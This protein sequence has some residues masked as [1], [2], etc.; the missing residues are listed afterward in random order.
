M[1][2]VRNSEVTIEVWSVF[3]DFCFLVKRLISN[4]DLFFF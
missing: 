2:T 1:T 4:L 3:L